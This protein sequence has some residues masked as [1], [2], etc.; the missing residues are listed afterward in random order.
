M[1]RSGSLWRIQRGSP[2]AWA[3]APRRRQGGRSREVVDVAPPKRRP[4]EEQWER[5]CR[6][7]HPSRLPPSVQAAGPARVAAVPGSP[8][9]LLCRLCR[10]HWGSPWQPPA[11]AARLGRRGAQ[12][13]H[14]PHRC[15]APRVHLAHLV[16]V[17]RQL[18][19][20]WRQGGSGRPSG[21]RPVGP[22][23]ALRRPS[24][25]WRSWW[26][27][28]S[29]SRGARLDRPEG[30]AGATVEVPRCLA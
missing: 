9:C 14:S 22:G 12:V 23:R 16:R 29:R 2:A 15:H 8:C 5:P 4:P 13:R 7:R 25:H 24:C 30:M 11:P 21:H 26:P 1:C 18:R 6:C 28:H 10:S 19:R 17:R 27:A 20:A 3:A